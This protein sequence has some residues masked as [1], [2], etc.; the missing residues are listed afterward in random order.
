MSKGAE[1]DLDALQH[2]D[3]RAASMPVGLLSDQV[4]SASST[5]QKESAPPESPPQDREA[6]NVEV[7]AVPTTPVS[8]VVHGD[9]QSVTHDAI[10]ASPRKRPR[11]STSRSPYFP[12]MPTSCIPFPSI[13]APSFGLIQERL[14]HDPFRLLVAV[15][16]LNKTKGG[17]AVPVFWEVMERYPTPEDLAGAK[18]EDLVSMIGHLGLQNQRT[19]TCI[20]LSKK[21]VECTPAKGIRYRRLHYP[22][23]G[24]GQDIRRSE[25]PLDDD[26]ARSAWEIA[27]L[28]GV[29]PYAI[30]SWR[31]FCRDVLRGLA[32]GWNCEGAELSTFEPEWKR[33]L[34]QDKELRAF[35]RWMWLRDGWEWDPLT[36]KRALAAEDML[37]RAR[38]GGTA[39][40]RGDGNW[41]LKSGSEEGDKVGDTIPPSQGSDEADK[42]P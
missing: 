17:A 28:P 42:N 7:L 32:T 3:L 16:F 25:P 12:K 14:A 5:S 24:D 11:Q 20:S 31:I 15:I 13:S 8:A 36:G 1:Q 38:H 41:D 2:H 9:A 23:K 33:V 4:A 22:K 27:H 30:D 35:L 37:R 26:D 39:H 29:G 40:E 19:A 6:V 21:W 34:P 10:S 18:S